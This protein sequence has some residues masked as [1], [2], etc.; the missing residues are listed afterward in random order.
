MSDNKGRTH[1]PG[2]RIADRIRSSLVLKLNIRMLGQLLSV[3]IL[4]NILAS[5]L[6]AGAIL[7]KAESG[8]QDLINVYEL[9]QNATREQSMAMG[10]YEIMPIEASGQGFLLPSLLQKWLPLRTPEAR[11]SITVPDF[12]LKKPL[13]Q[14]IE[15][16]EYHMIVESK[17]ANYHITYALEADIRIYRFLL[18]V[19]VGGQLVY[20]ISSIRR[21][22]QAIRRILKPLSDMAE[23]AK[24][25]RE[26][27]TSM[28]TGVSGSGI[29]DLAGAISTIDANR[30]DRRISV[31]S[32]QDELKD[33]AY[34]INDML[35]RISQSYQF[36]VRFVSDASHE[37]RTPISVIQGYAN[38][39][40]RWG[41]HDEN[42][43]QE[44]IDAIK[45]ETES[46]KIL[47]EQLLFLA[48]GDNET[49][50]LHKTVFDICQVIDEIV[51]ETRL[52][53]PAHIFETYLDCETYVD[54][55][56][57]LIKQAIRILVDNSIKYTPVGE[58]IALKVV[59]KEDSVYIRVQDNGIGIAPE[60]VYHIF[61][62][63]YRSDES[64]ARKTG[65][66]GLGLAIAKWIVERHE[67]H[68]EVISRV[69]IG[70]RITAVLPGVRKPICDTEKN[71]GKPSVVQ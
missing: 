57:Q 46:M 64:R 56:Q 29:K 1:A 65:G 24:S 12:P 33:L 49:I 32:S 66:S 37:L 20:L 41:K 40:D 61:D 55:D 43:M 8:V 62:R 42:T 16:A 39:L 13:M 27:M 6:F 60:D 28:G 21:N 2:P 50:Q 4:G 69:D 14:R 35:N 48:R 63:F 38:L 7:W 3:F 53:D 44:S 68:F 70:T 15:Q 19:V 9:Q 52:I 26:G 17:G 18:L 10:S 71:N 67:G 25:L 31:D 45:S 54:G 36:Q 11:R 58:R 34:A 51:K 47:V 30:L 5:I 23:T 22:T 59:S